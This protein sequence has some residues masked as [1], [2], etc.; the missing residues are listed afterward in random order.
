V[1]ATL[2]LTDV[3]AGY[4]NTTVVRDVSLEIKPGSVVALLGANGAGKTTTIRA[5]A[6]TASVSRGSIYLDG[7]NI[8]S[9]KPSARAR[10]GL[11]TVLEG[12]SIYQTLTVQENLLMFTPLSGRATD[13]IDLAV[14]AFPALRQRLNQLAGSLSGGEQQMLALSRA[15]LAH[16]KIIILDELSTGLAP[17]VV[18]EIYGR[19]R[20]LAGAGVSLLIVEQYVDLVLELADWVYVMARGSIASSGPATDIGLK[21]I[22]ASYLGGDD[23]TAAGEHLEPEQM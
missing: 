21:S 22:L 16:P 6:G 2:S 4:E 19:L 3:D 8:T 15:Y 1:K 9:L 20:G 7:T 14:E 18:G 17:L 11:C 12:R 23:Q 5:I 10:M 13:N